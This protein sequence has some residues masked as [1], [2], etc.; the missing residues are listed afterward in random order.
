MTTL[1]DIFGQDEA[2]ETLLNAYRSE[3]LPHGLIFGG[4]IGVGKGTAA[5]GLAAL[6]LCEKPKSAAPCGKCESCTLMN[7]DNH[8]DYQGVY[9][10]LVRFEKKESAARDLSIDVVRA[11]VID[12]AGRKSSMGRG[13]V[14][15]IEEADL[16][17]RAAQNALLKTLEEPPGRM[18][19]MLLT[20]QPDCLLPTIRSRTQLV[21]F[22]ALDQK[23]VAH[24]LEKRKIDKST[25][26]EA[27]ALSEGSLGVALKWIEDGVI[28]SARALGK[29]IDALLAGRD[30]GSLAESFK[31]A[32][33]AYAARQLEHDEKA[34]KDQ[35]TREG[36]ALYLTIAS[37]QFRRRL[38][39][40][41]DPDAL[42][43]ICIAIDAIVRAEEYLASNVSP[44]LVLQQLA[45]ALSRELVG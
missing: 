39:D 19:V 22:H 4:P 18:L 8:P 28:E 37:N 25:A 29:Q 43:S 16:M 10:Q 20:D 31:K 13:R 9:R 23:L 44:G 38:S 2:V 17:T 36:V 5:S 24:E 40:T 42:E 26:S 15:V 41:R 35:M 34:S 27:A 12:P 45:T 1:A 6:F 7:A 3:R 32:A 11:Y 30:A 21:R 33:D 14:F